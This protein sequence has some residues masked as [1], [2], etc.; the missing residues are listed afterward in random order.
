MNAT[1]NYLSVETSQRWCLL[2][3]KLPDCQFTQSLTEQKVFTGVCHRTAGA[4]L[5][6]QCLWLCVWTYE[7]MCV[8]AR[9]CENRKALAVNWRW[10]E[11]SSHRGR[12][13]RGFPDLLWLGVCRQTEGSTKEKSKKK[14]DVWKTS[15]AIVLPMLWLKHLSRKAKT[16]NKME[17]VTLTCTC[18]F[19]RITKDLK[20][21]CLT[22]TVLQKFVSWANQCN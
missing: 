15:S 4:E 17:N 5:Q 18:T 11:I 3:P 6:E 13:A 2:G 7:C 19:V 20:K 1:R 12:Q 9:V 14:T 21:I 10:A 16:L 22:Y 8:C